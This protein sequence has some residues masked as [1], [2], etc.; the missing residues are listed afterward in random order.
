MAEQSTSPN[1]EVEETARTLTIRMP[2]THKT[3]WTQIC[4]ISK[5]FLQ[6]S[7]ACL[8]PVPQ[9]R[10]DNKSGA[11]SALK[12]DCSTPE[13]SVVREYQTNTTTC[14]GRYFPPASGSLVLETRSFL[15]DLPTELL[16]MIVHYAVD[17]YVLQLE[18]LSHHKKEFVLWQPRTWSQMAVYSLC[19]T[20]RAI[21]IERWGVPRHNALPFCP[22][23]DRLRFRPILRTALEDREKEIYKELHPPRVRSLSLPYASSNEGYS[24]PAG[25]EEEEE[26]DV[27]EESTDEEESDSEKMVTISEEGNEYEMTPLPVFISRGA[28]P[29]DKFH[30]LDNDFL[31]Q[32]QDF[33]VNVIRRR[34][35]AEVRDFRMYALNKVLDAMPGIQRLSLEVHR[36]DRCKPSWWELR[37]LG[38]S[39][40]V[41]YRKEDLEMM[42]EFFDRCRYSRRLRTLQIFAMEAT[43]A[44]CLS[45]VEGPKYL[46]CDYILEE[47]DDH[48]NP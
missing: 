36:L 24:S 26:E 40:G 15:Q 44:H 28:A 11:R 21:A 32:I 47:A 19:R 29:G 17:P 1:L 48:W 35:Y 39:G 7:L 42:R 45:S 12:A 5:P 16:E 20:V 25:D 43:K 33:S 14:P 34:P 4:R 23:I 38:E 10:D 30:E 22:K 41:Y 46:A 27:S 31:R 9:V 3:D 37:R 2:P 6:F 13:G 18:Y 8:D